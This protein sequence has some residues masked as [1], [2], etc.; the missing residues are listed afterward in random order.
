MTKSIVTGDAGYDIRFSEASDEPHLKEWLSS[1]AVRKWL[2]PSSDAD[3]DLFVRNWIGFSRYKSSLT[4]TYNGQVVGVA[5]IFL[6]PYLKVAHLC[7]M[8]IAVDPRM[9]RRGIGTSLVKNIKNLAKTRF[10]LESMHVEVF[11]NCPVIPVLQNQGFVEIVRQENFVHLE[12]GFH[13]RR[14]FEVVL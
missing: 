9:Q 11:G 13:P 14:I 7:M 2:P 1:K 10:R 8:Y 3:A 4:A 12:D 6:M 5:T